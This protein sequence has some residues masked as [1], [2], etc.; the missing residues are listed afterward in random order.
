MRLRVRTSPPS[1]FLQAAIAAALVAV[2]VVSVSQTAGVSMVR[3]VENAFGAGALHVPGWSCRLGA[4][5]VPNRRVL[6]LYDS[7]GKFAAYGAQTGV[8]AA[9]FASRFAQTVRQPVTSY[10]PGEMAH[11]AAVVYVGTNYGE[12]LPGAFLAD[13]R[14]GLRKVLWLGGNA[15]QLTNR[16][17]VARNG[18]REGPDHIA[19]FVRVQY[20]HVSLTINNNDLNGIDILNP[21]KP[22]VVATAV[23]A[24]GRSVPWAVQSGRLTYV[25]EIPLSSGGGADRSFA[26]AD[27]MAGLFGKVTNRHWALIRLEDVGPDSDPTQLTAIANL[28]SARKVPFAVAVYPLYIGPANQHPRQR[29]SLE[30]RPQVVEALKYMLAKGG[31]LILHGY[32]HQLGDSPNPN[33][34][35]SGQDY[36]FLWVRYNSRHELIYANPVANDPVGWAR[37]RIMQALEAI[38][39]AGLPRP[40]LWEFPEYGASPA[41]YR[42]VARMFVARFERGNYA[43]GRAGHEQLQTL[44]EQTPP[45]VV[46]DVYGGLVLP[47]TLG[48]VYGPH[49][50]ASGAGSVSAVLAAAA[51]QKAAVR[52]NVASVYYHPFLGVAPLRGIVDGIQHE[53]YRFVSACTALRG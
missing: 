34:G 5:S 22:T 43:A 50:P 20:R 2:T 30:S 49:V 12:P 44:T 33:N 51:A 21:A 27:L 28:L 3:T 31:T 42:L 8:L 52:D 15:Y 38:R 40:R 24:R 53:G 9:N 29:I 18:W 37:H 16:A 47:E 26:V 7:T 17:Y 1:R 39:T 32:T 19:H 14:S 36:E 45:F 25:S 10:R 13:V 46:R 6:V 23:T 4:H 35:Q 11:Y 41:E 48:Y